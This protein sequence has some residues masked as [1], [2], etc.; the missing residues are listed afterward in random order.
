MG[1]SE[2]YNG[3]GFASELVCTGTGINHHC[4]TEWVNTALPGYNGTENPQDVDDFIFAD[5]QDVQLNVY[6]YNFTVNNVHRAPSH[7]QVGYFGWNRASR[8]VDRKQSNESGWHRI[9]SSHG[10]GR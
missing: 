9:F 10:F 4:Y 2:V 6:D 8:R 3:K 7:C 1:F 5:Q